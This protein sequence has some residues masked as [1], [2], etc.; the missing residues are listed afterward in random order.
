MAAEQVAGTRRYESRKKKVWLGGY[1]Q[2]AV[3][4]F[5]DAPVAFN[6]MPANKNEADYWPSLEAKTERALGQRVQAAAFDRG[7]SIRP[8]FEHNTRRGIATV[9]PWRKWRPGMEREDADAERWDRHGVP[10]CDHCGGPGLFEEAGLGFY[11]DA[12]HE[13]RIRFRCQLELTPQCR[14]TQSIACEEEWRMLVP[15]SR[16]SETYHALG[17]MSKSME[18]VFRHWRDRYGVA[19]NNPDTRP[20]RPG[21]GWQELRASAALLVEWFCLSLRHGWLG[22]HRRRNTEQPVPCQGRR[23]L[24]IMLGARR[25][26]SLDLP[27]GPAAVAAGLAPP[28]GGGSPP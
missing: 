2:R 23:R 27:Y 25:K 10:R 20:R 14:C 18:H 13:P 26:A 7:Y 15:L 3:S 24:R 22:S 1:F 11:F 8:V 5:V 9:A 21:M 16:R 28:G 17:D 4:M 19:G 6:V 12:N